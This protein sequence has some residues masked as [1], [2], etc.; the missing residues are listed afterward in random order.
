MTMTHRSPGNRCVAGTG[1][2]S[3][4]CRRE[5]VCRSAGGGLGG[6]HRTSESLDA[7]DGLRARTTGRA[8]A[9]VRAARA[10]PLERHVHQ[11]SHAVALLAHRRTSAHPVPRRLQYAVA[12]RHL[13]SAHCFDLLVRQLAAAAAAAV[14]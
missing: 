4:V 12:I 10:P 11:S 9:A 3:G 2:R 8:R 14:L 1:T 5:D 6:E 7:A 13:P